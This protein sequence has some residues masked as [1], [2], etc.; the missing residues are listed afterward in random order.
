MGEGFLIAGGFMA[1]IT[2]KELEDYLFE[3]TPNDPYEEEEGHPLGFNYENILRQVNI[4]GYGIVDL[5][6]IDITCQG[7]LMPCIDI[8]IIELKKG[9]I[10][11]NALGQICR[12]KAALDRFFADLRRL[13]GHKYLKNLNVTGTLVGSD[14]N[15]QGDLCYAVESIPWLSLYTYELDLREGIT[16]ELSSGWHNPSEDFSSLHK[17]IKDDF[18]NQFITAYT[19]PPLEFRVRGKK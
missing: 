13:K 16:F 18:I 19:E 1:I 6:S 11:Y 17:K 15:Q 4:Q 3:W 8:N 2:E 5:L 12:Y 10:D 7:E 14:L 9:I